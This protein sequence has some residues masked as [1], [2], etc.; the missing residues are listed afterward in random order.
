MNDDINGADSTKLNQRE[1]LSYY[2]ILSTGTTLGAEECRNDRL[3]KTFT[4]IISLPRAYLKALQRQEI[5]NY[6][7]SS[8]FSPREKVESF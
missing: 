3:R 1:G 5:A 6:L 8:F 2:P 7:Q 4:D